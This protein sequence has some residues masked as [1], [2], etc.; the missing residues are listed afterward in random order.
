[1]TPSTSFPL[2]SPSLGKGSVPDSF[3]AKQSV[4]MASQGAAALP[5][6]EAQD[7]S[8][9]TTGPCVARTQ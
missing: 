3:R 6:P 7:M 4:S 5:V 1:M 9:P 8:L 2:T